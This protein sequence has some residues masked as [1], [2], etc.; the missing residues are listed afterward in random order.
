MVSGLQANHPEMPGSQQQSAELV[1]FTRQGCC[2]C[3]GLAERLQALDPAPRLT[4]V[5]VDGDPALQARFGLE[6]PVLAQPDGQGRL[7]LLP[8]VPPRLAGAAL[9]QWLRRHSASAA[10]PP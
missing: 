3:E 9:A 5:D 6:V 1:L 7:R 4:L 8:R 2:L 10:A